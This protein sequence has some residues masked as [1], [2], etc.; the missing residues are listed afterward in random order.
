MDSAFNIAIPKSSLAAIGQLSEN[1]RLGFASKNPALHRGIA[2]SKSTLALGLPE[3][4]GKTAS[5]HVVAANNQPQSLQEQI[6]QLRQQIQQLTE[7]AK[8]GG[9]CSAMEVGGNATLVIGGDVTLLGTAE[10]L[11]VVG[12]PVG[13]VTQA[14]GG[15]GMAVGGTVSSLGWLGKKFGVC[16]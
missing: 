13:L 12:L 10:D 16:E 7:K 1:S 6:T 4:S 15:I 9:V 3:W 8:E 14:S 5:D 2:W 11:T